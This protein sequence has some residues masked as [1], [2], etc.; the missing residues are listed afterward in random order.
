MSQLQPLVRFSS[1]MLRST[2][3]FSQVRWRSI[4]EVFGR[5]SGVEGE[6]VTRSLS[7]RTESA[8]STAYLGVRQFGAGAGPVPP[9]PARSEEV[10]SFG[11]SARCFETH[12][13]RAHMFLLFVRGLPSIIVASFHDRLF[14]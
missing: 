8:S 3:A 12:I 4:D 1:S 5:G 14:L 10:R 11:S 9:R 7:Q 6:R 2:A 13:P